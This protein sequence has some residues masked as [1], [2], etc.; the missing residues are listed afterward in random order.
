MKNITL[1]LL[2]ALFVLNAAWAQTPV[3]AKAQSKPIALTGAV[4]H[5]G[6]GQVIQNSIIAFDKGK[7]TLVLDATTSKVDLS[8]Y[9]A[10]NVAGK[11]VYPGFILP[12]SQIGLQ[13]VS[14]VRAMNDYTERG[15]L[16][17][18]I[19]A[20]ISYN[21]DTEY[22]ASFRFNG[23]LL[24]EAT[25]T[26]GL[27]SGSSSVME[28]E[29]WNWEDAAHT[30]DMGIH[31]NWPPM[32]RRQFD[33]N[34]FSFSESANKDYEKQ[35]GELEQFFV[36][37]TAYGKLATKETNLKFEAMQGLFDGKKTLLMIWL[38]PQPKVM[39]CRSAAK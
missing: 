9:E 22:T 37:A 8:R 15:E 31:M 26:G 3:P 38:N 34:T 36:E 18:N 35:V 6:N 27:I 16:N 28:M 29:G 17:P 10:I 25:P 11:H 33:F 4:A 7:L 32:M 19:R 5:L 21:T 20:L 2:I 12:N 24:A 13:E 1:T 30:I 14:S 23:V 39:R